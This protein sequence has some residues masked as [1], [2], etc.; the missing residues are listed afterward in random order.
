MT[1]LYESKAHVNPGGKEVW[2]P[3]PA[4]HLK[5]LVSLRR[6]RL[7]S[8]DEKQ[9]QTAK[10]EGQN[11]KRD[12]VQPME[13]WP[14]VGPPIPPWMRTEVVPRHPHLP[15]NTAKWATMSCSIWRA[16]EGKVNMSSFQSRGKPWHQA[17]ESDI[18][19]LS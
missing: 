7:T 6:Q 9:G 10:K 18:K 2:R 1:G 11:P 14:P 15:L 5:D 8:K 4:A 3:K 12:T 17:Q 19:G 16:I 13:T